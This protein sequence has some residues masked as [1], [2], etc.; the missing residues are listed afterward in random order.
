MRHP[1]TP[2]YAKVLAL[3][4][5]AYAVSPIDLIPDFIPFIGY[6]DDVVIVPAGMALV[7]RLIPPRVMEECRS[8]VTPDMLRAVGWIR[9]FGLGIVLVLWSAV[10]VAIV[11]L[12]LWLLRRL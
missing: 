1:D 10:A 6:L 12:M 5:A 4:V 8:R 7:V 2:W 11:A 3:L 9:R